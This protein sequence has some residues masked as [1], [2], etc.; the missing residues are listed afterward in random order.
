MKKAIAL[1]C[2]AV[3]ALSLAA[4]SSQTGK[5][6][7]N[8]QV[9]GKIT[10]VNGTSITLQLGELKQK[11]MEDQSGQTPPEMPEGD[12]QSGQTPPEKP[13]GDS[14]NGQTPP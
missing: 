12:S 14:Q 8:Q 5:D 11:E 4:C 6:W 1:S 10:A 13:E 3:M 2:S 9:T 7:S